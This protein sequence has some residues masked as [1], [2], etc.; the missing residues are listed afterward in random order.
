MEDYYT[1]VNKLSEERLMD[2]IQGLYKKLMALSE[3]SSIYPQVLQMIETAET[4]YQDRV[5]RNR[6]KNSKSSEVINIGQID[7]TVYTPAYTSEELLIA[8]VSQYTKGR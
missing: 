4:A 7:E 2:E 6:Y 8:V 3:R 5:Y 1:K